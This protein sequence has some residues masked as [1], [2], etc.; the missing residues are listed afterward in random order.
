LE[1]DVIRHE[2]KAKNP[3]ITIHRHHMRETTLLTEGKR[4][5]VGEREFLIVVLTEEFLS[6][7]TKIFIDAMTYQ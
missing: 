3:E 6:S 1:R 7:P 2:Q 5:T 4:G